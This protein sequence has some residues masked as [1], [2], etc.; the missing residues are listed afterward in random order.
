[1]RYYFSCILFLILSC[2]TTKPALNEIKPAEEILA[3]VLT[4]LP[5]TVGY[6]SKMESYASIY[7]DT[8]FEIESLKSGMVEYSTNIELKSSER[9][10]WLIKES[11]KGVDSLLIHCLT[12]LKSVDSNFIFQDCE[13]ENEITEFDDVGNPIVSRIETIKM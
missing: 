2:K 3:C 7:K 9:Y 10:L 6:E 12:P 11:E 5:L 8:I 1:M 4:N 13:I